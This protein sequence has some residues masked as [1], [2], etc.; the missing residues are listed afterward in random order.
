MWLSTTNLSILPR[1]GPYLK[2]SGV[3]KWRE[4][5]YFLIILNKRVRLIKRCIHY[6]PF[7]SAAEDR[8][9]HSNLSL[10]DSYHTCLCHVCLASSRL[11]ILS[12]LLFLLLQSSEA[13]LRSIIKGYLTLWEETAVGWYDSKSRCLSACAEDCTLSP[14]AKLRASF[15]LLSNLCL[16]PRQL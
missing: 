2:V 16:N 9:V 12:L 1:P 5:F 10:Y 8:L 6:S 7:L 14:P 13:A 4:L 11:I 15:G 3:E